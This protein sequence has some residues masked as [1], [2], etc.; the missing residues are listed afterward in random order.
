[1]RN[2]SNGLDVQLVGTNETWDTVRNALQKNNEEADFFAVVTD[3]YGRDN[4]VLL[5][6]KSVTESIEVFNP[7]K[8]GT[9]FEVMNGDLILMQKNRTVIIRSWNKNVNKEACVGDF[10]VGEWMDPWA[11]LD[12]VS[13]KAGG[14]LCPLME[15]LK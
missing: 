8:C 1:M 9:Y 4:I 3:L 6:K 13:K 15:V 5:N 7:Q 14:F 11:V 10:L 12:H 2:Y